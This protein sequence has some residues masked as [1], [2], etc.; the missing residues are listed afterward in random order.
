MTQQAVV[1]P[2]SGI[3]G[4]GELTGLDFPTGAG[5]SD[6]YAP[7]GAGIVGEESVPPPPEDIYGS[8]LSSIAIHEQENH[9]G[10][11]E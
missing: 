2:N 6:H 11:I 1:A 3:Y 9:Y 7:I 10:L 5:I 4:K 8:R